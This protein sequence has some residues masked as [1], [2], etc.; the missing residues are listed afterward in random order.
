MKRTTLFYASTS[1]IIGIAVAWFR[2][3]WTALAPT[4]IE[5][6]LGSWD[7]HQHFLGF[8]LFR[9][10]EWAWPLGWIK[11]YLAPT[12]TS[13]GLTDSIPL[14]AYLGKAFS[15]Y[16][17]EHFQY[18]GFWLFLSMCLQGIW[19]YSLMGFISSKTLNRSL[20]SFLFILS[21]TMLH[22]VSPAS[23]IALSAHWLVLSSLWIYFNTTL[24]N[25]GIAKTTCHWLGWFAFAGLV[26]PYLACM[27]FAIACVCHW[28]LFKS[29]TT[30]FSVIQNTSALLVFLLILGFEW[31]A[32]GVFNLPT[33]DLSAIGFGYFSM[34]INAPVNAMQ[35][36]NFGPSF[37][38]LT[39]GQYEGF[40]YLGLGLLI[41][42]L[43]VLL[44]LSV[45][46][47]LRKQLVA[48]LRRHQALIWLC[49]A[50][51][52]FSIGSYIGIGS[53][54]FFKL[55]I[56][57]NDTY[58]ILGPFRS[59]GRFF[60]PVN[61]LMVFG[62]L[63]CLV[64]F[65]PQTQATLFLIAALCFQIVDL[66]GSP[67]LSYNTYAKVSYQNH[68]QNPG[69]EKAFQTFKHVAAVPPF[70][71]T[72]LRP[73]DYRDFLLLGAKHRIPVNMGYSARNSSSMSAAYRDELYKTVRNGNLDPETL[74]VFKNPC[75]YF[76]NEQKQNN[77]C[78]QWDSYVVCYD[79]QAPL[80]IPDPKPPQ[81]FCR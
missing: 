32:T 80:S 23:H 29:K 77:H 42:Y 15:S 38:L 69:W 7:A 55:P 26:H 1:G 81:H 22:R 70:K 24:R 9:F 66:Y 50:L 57:E 8:H 44:R 36:S 21:P 30:V 19:G 10:E 3:G 13:I 75:R 25:N 27:G 65:L 31:T 5:W 6:L 28:E 53:I 2:Y 14:L 54:R 51:T 62:A 58:A 34:N 12:G 79:A 74:Y 68:L 63:F 71:R 67:L 52:L 4:H 37:E 59:S 40:N 17:P 43:F 78:H 47:E 48:H 72:L 73:D 56:S 45:D 76:T 60:W 46:R 49:L 35:L 64:R 20:G 16:L 41:I 18:F 39:E 11:G 61:Y 33:Q